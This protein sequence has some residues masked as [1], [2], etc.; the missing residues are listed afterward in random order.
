[1]VI[2]LLMEVVVV[3]ECMWVLNSFV[4]R[5]YSLKYSDWWL[6]CQVFWEWCSVDS[7]VCLLLYQFIFLVMIVFIGCFVLNWGGLLY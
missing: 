5:S 7:L 4:L 2:S 1:M 6:C 3:C